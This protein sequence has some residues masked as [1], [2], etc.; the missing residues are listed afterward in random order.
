MTSILYVHIGKSHYV[1]N[2]IDGLI[3]EIMSDEE[4]G[5]EIGKYENKVLVFY[6]K[7]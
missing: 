3:Y 7:I 1:E 4:C 5:E 6:K 2:E